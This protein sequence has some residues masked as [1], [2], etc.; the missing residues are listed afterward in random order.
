MAGAVPDGSLPQ[1]R[2]RK[3]ERWLDNEAIDTQTY[4]L[5]YVDV[6]LNSLPEGPLVLVIDA[7]EV[8]KDCMALIV[9]LVYQK[10]ALPLCWIVVPGKKGHLSEENHLT[11]LEKAKPLLPADRQVIFLGDGEFDGVALQAKL[12]EYGWDYACRTAK[13]VQLKEEDSAWFAPQ[14]LLV[15]PGDDLWLEDVSFTLQ[16]Y[17]PVQVGIRWERGMAHPLIL[18]SNFA[19]LDEAF[20][21]YKHRF[22]IETF[23]SDQ[24]SRGF[25]LCHSHISDTAHLERLLI[26]CCLAYLWVVCLGAWVVRRGLLPR[27]H[28][29]SRCDWSLF[30]IGLAWIE[31]CLNKS[32]P[33][34]VVFH[35]PPGN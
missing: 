5:P 2:L 3:M 22:R 17:G 23:F 27:I 16:G 34:K 1:S 29:K 20:Y 18:V 10:R 35:V 7:S 25:Y 30:H 21:W 9:N 24:K 33:L 4:Y 13:N 15:E 11:L 28:R 32:L 31:Y 14:D 8:G 12:T 6:L 26:A 19:V